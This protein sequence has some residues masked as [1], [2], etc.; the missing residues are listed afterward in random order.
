MVLLQQ[1]KINNVDVSSYVVNWSKDE[2]DGEY[3]AVLT[4]KMVR[5]VLNIVNITPG[6]TIEIWRGTTTATDLKIFSGYIEKATPEGGAIT[7]QAKD[8]LWNLVRNEVTTIYD[9]TGSQ[10]G[11]IS[12]IFL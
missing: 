9:S 2:A 7:I 6:M 11:K 4:L 3:L 12:A 5:G 8:K 10:A 1:T